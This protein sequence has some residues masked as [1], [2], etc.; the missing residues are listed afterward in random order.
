MGPWPSDA[1]E[2]QGLQ[3]WLAL[4][5]AAQPRWRPD[6]LWRAAVG[7]VFTTGPRGTVGIGATGDP[8]WA[9]AVTMRK[10]TLV[11]AAVV[12][13]RFDA[14]YLPGL[15]ALREGR[16]LHRAVEGLQTRPDVVLV[17]ATGRDHP[18]GAGLAVHLGWVLDLPTIGVT[19][20]PLEDPSRSIPLAPHPDIRPVR[21]HP[22]W[23]TDAETAVEVV[24]AV[25]RVRTPAPLREARHL[26]R[27]ARSGSSG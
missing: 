2:L 16:V 18:R 13:D 26:A 1:E 20:R 5:E 19:D 22:A 14:P 9:A 21:V 23:R 17:D 25:Q 11:D 10:G 12:S 6:H 27:T 4:L 8:A 24:R 7:A 3:H 15:L